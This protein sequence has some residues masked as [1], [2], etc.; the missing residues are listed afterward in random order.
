LKVYPIFVC[1]FGIL[2]KRKHSQLENGPAHSR[3]NF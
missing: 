1:T 3:P 2:S